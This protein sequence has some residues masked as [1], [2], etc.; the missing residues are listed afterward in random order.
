M[1]FEEFKDAHHGPGHA[2]ATP[3]PLSRAARPVLAAGL[4][5]TADRHHA[6]ALL[7]FFD[8]HVRERAPE[9]SAAVRYF[10][11]GEERWRESSTWPPPEMREAKIRKLLTEAP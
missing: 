6:D 4:L 9:R 5:S 2:Q 7:A 11:M 8:A 3:T 10:T 1:T